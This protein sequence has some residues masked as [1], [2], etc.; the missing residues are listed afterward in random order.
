MAETVRRDRHLFSP[1]SDRPMIALRLIALL[2]VSLP[3]LAE[4]GSATVSEVT[5]I[6]DGDSFR[7][8]IE[9]WPPIIGQRAPI[10]V[11]SVDAPD[12]R[13]KL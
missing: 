1:S 8:N 4:Y 13:G 7:V 11:K 2:F 10:R 12:L 3:A 5:S 6:Y 9:G